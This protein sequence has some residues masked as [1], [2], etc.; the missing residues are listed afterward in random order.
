VSLGAPDGEAGRALWGKLAAKISA[1][2]RRM[3]NRSLTASNRS[4]WALSEANE[5]VAEE[6]R[7]GSAP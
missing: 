5:F 1:V 2:I 3:S 7:Y 4:T 6:F